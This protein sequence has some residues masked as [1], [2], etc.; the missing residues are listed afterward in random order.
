[1]DRLLFRYLDA[2]Y[3]TKKN[4]LLDRTS[5]ESQRF[6]K[7]YVPFIIGMFI[8]AHQDSVHIAN[9]ANIS[10]KMSSEKQFV[11]LLNSIRRRRRFSRWPKKESDIKVEAIAEY[12]DVSVKRA[13][14]YLLL[15]TQK[16]LEF[17]VEAT[18]YLRKKK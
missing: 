9:Q 14:E 10:P 11:Y 18:E 4:Y 3:F 15:H 17:I 6:S 13:K 8:A 7:E 1:M 16:E 12:Y 2:I 5:E